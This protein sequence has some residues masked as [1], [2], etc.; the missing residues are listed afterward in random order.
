MFHKKS[1]SALPTIS[2]K[3]K[4]DNKN[5]E[6][7]E[8]VSKSLLRALHS[9]VEV[10]WL[11]HHIDQIRM[12]FADCKRSI[13]TS[14][15]SKKEKKLA[16]GDVN[17]AL[18]SLKSLKDKMQEIEAEVDFNYKQDAE[19]QKLH[20]IKLSPIAKKCKN[21]EKEEVRREKEISKMWADVNFLNVRAGL[22]DE[23]KLRLDYLTRLRNQCIF[24]RLTTEVLLNEFSTI[25]KEGYEGSLKYVL[26]LQHTL[27]EISKSVSLNIKISEL[28][29]MVKEYDV[30]KNTGK[31]M[32]AVDLGLNFRCN[33][34]AE[35]EKITVGLE[36]F[37]RAMIPFQKAQSYNEKASR[38]NNNL[39]FAPQRM[40]SVSPISSS[41]AAS[42]PRSN[43]SFF[44][45]QRIAAMSSPT[46]IPPVDQDSNQATVLTK[47]SK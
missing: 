4:D 43:G 24:E 22:N 40:S 46:V 10:N 25:Q 28:I 14:A 1:K 31:C 44:G 45:V 29:R 5:N 35:V 11:Y 33:D 6:Q 37:P 30:E 32:E 18:Q 3:E 26:L 19:W 17:I 12:H 38:A 13:K 23:E 8:L 16:I 47:S 34:S 27:S 42:S 7:S 39:L 15:M 36:A 9:Q 41:P 21:K 20:G 2:R